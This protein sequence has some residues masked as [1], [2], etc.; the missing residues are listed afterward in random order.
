MDPPIAWNDKLRAGQAADIGPVDLGCWPAGSVPPDKMRNA[1]VYA[2]TIQCEDPLASY[3]VCDFAPCGAIAGQYY[4]TDNGR[5]VWKAPAGVNAT[6][7]G[8][9][10]MT[11]KM[12]DAQNGQLNQQG[13]NAL[14]DFP[15]YGPVI[16]GAR[17]LAGADV[18]ADDYKYIPVRRLALYIEQSIRSGTQ[19]AVFEAN[20]EKLWSHLRLI[21]GSFMYNLW[22]QGAVLDQFVKCDATT[23]TPAD[24]DAGV[25]NIQIGFAPVKPAEFVVLF[26]QQQTAQA[27]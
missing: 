10:A 9:V 13:I 19:W 4:S 17:T 24:I 5:G 15:T 1:A 21:I 8:V 7:S 12:D 18:L 2:P 25:V 22:Q 11:V 6:L 3:S 26:I 14:R 20:D 23:T 16:W 27:D